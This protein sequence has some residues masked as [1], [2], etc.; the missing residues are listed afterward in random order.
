MDFLVEVKQI[1]LQDDLISQGAR[2]RIYF[3]GNLSLIPDEITK[4]VKD[5]S[6][7][8]IIGRLDERFTIDLKAGDKIIFRGSPWVILDTDEEVSVAPSKSIGE[9]PRWIGEDIPVPHSIAQEASS[10]LS[11]HN[12][13]NLPL[14]KDAQKSL[15]KYR[16]EIEGSG[17]IPSPSRATLEKHDHLIILHYPGGTRLNRTI[18][19]LL[20][21][22][23]NS[24]CGDSVGF[25]SDPYRILLD[26]N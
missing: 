11:D 10:R 5:V 3:H 23:L 24:R 20:S 1:R 9:L 7:Q 14:S 15:D 26:P 21:S 2:S 22:L 25:Q 12:W 19:L 18:G 17:V 6:T 13:K 16:Q 4:S 8:K